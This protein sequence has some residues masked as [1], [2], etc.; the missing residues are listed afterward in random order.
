MEVY[1]QGWGSPNVTG[2]RGFC[3][4]QTE[5]RLDQRKILAKPAIK[6]LVSKCGIWS[7]RSGRWAGL[8]GHG[9]P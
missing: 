1:R 6:R 4:G 3:R 5:D 7:C 8:L 2:T 9:F